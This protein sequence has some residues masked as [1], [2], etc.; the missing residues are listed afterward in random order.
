MP[1]TQ[2]MSETRRDRDQKSRLMTRLFSFF[3]RR[4][5]DKTPAAL[6]KCIIKLTF[7][8]RVGAYLPVTHDG[9]PNGEQEVKQDWGVT[10]SNADPIILDI[11]RFSLYQNAPNCNLLLENRSH[12]KQD[13]HEDHVEHSPDLVRGIDGGLPKKKTP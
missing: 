2:N 10:F 1:S 5:H 9:L 12:H 3:Y 4:A 11:E 6:Y 8:L 13:K 7:H